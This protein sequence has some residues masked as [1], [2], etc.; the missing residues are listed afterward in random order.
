MVAAPR[1]FHL[2][3]HEQLTRRVLVLSC[4]G[5]ALLTG[6]PVLLCDGQCDSFI[7][8]ACAE[9][10]VFCQ[11]EEKDRAYCVFDLLSL[12]VPMALLALNLSLLVVLLVR[13]ARKKVYT[14]TCR[15]VS[16][17][18]IEALSGQS[19]SVS[20]E[21]NPAEAIPPI[22]VEEWRSQLD[23][24]KEKEASLVSHRTPPA[25]PLKPEVKR[26]QVGPRALRSRHCESASVV[27]TALGNQRLRLREQ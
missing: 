11:T 5:L 6:L 19:D 18:G 17:V 3:D 4:V 8:Y 12:L 10:L 14:F 21:R 24:P 20:N 9:A 25:E 15:K 2:L 26:N 7:R 23:E 16:H 22:C 1:R 27:R 13:N